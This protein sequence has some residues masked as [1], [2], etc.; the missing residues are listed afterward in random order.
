[1]PTQEA[2]EKATGLMSSSEATFTNDE[3]LVF[4]GLFKQATTGDCTESQP[5]YINQPAY[6]K[7][8]AW[9]EYKGKSSD[10]A[11]TEYVKKVASLDN[12]TGKQC[13]ELLELLD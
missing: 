8:K 1:M 4:Y 7:H 13:Q 5:L 6:R 9:V 11:M 10:E 3:K 2:F 12:E